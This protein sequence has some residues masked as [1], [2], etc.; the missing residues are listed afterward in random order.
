[1]KQAAKRRRTAKKRARKKGV[2][3]EK[4]HAIVQARAQGFLR[5]PNIT[6]IGIGY[7]HENDQPT[8]KLAIQ[9]TVRKKIDEDQPEAIAKLGTTIIPK[10]IEVD[11]QEIPTDV[12][13]R[14]YKPA[15]QLVA[16][17]QKDVRK[18]RL[19]TL[20]PGISVSHPSGTAG[21]LG[22]I[23]F[24]THT[25][26]ACMLSNWHVLNTPEGKL[27]DTVVQP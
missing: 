20:Q 11:G 27:G 9:F 23:V 16:E 17:M 1:M 21:T 7:K 14:E 2:D 5:D 6:S 3:M 10:S 22:L 18:Q 8:N 25:G 26:A 15:Y 24:D 13:E 12:I 4:L 19:A